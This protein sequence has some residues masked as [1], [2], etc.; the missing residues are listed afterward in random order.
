MANDALIKREAERGRKL[1]ETYA[2]SLEADRDAKRKGQ[3]ILDGSRG[4]VSP[5]GNVC[6][7]WEWSGRKEP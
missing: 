7:D 5:L 3:S 4:P 2:R 1:F 6:P